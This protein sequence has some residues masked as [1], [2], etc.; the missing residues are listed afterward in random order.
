M[1]RNA[2]LAEFKGREGE[3]ISGT[4]QRHEGRMIYIDLGRTNG[5]LPPNEKIPTEPYR[6]G[7]R[8][9]CYIVRVEETHRGPAIVLSRSHPR[10][11]LDLFKFEVPEL[12][13]GAVEVRAIAREAG[14]RPKIAVSSNEDS[15]DPTGSLVGQK[16]VRGQT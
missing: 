15:G 9:K 5:I 13:S 6:I 8:L 16:G 10:L 2:I 4:V 14:S 12:E 7:S 11:I 1:E 3:V